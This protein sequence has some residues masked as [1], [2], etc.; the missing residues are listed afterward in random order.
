MRDQP[1]SRWVGARLAMLPALL[2]AGCTILAPI[3]RPPEDRRFPVAF[4]TTEKV[5]CFDGQ[6]QSQLCDAPLVNA[7]DDFHGGLGRALWEMDKRRSELIGQAAERTTLNATY[8]ALLWPFGAYFLAKKVHHPGW[9]ALDVSAFAV[10]TYGLLGSG[11]PDRDKLYLKTSA[12]MAC[13]MVEFDADLYLGSEVI[14]PEPS[15]PVR[16]GALSLDERLSQLRAALAAFVARRDSVLARLEL[17]ASKPG[18]HGN[19]STQQ[20]RLLAMNAATAPTSPQDPTPGILIETDRLAAEAEQQLK[21]GQALK[22]RLDSSG[23]RLRLQR[24]RMEATLAE[25]LND[26]T[27]ALDSPLKRGGEIT[28]LVQDLMTASSQVADKV[29]KQSGSG[30]SEPWQPTAARLSGLTD[31]SRQCVIGLWTQERRTLREA[32]AAVAD[33]IAQHDERVNTAKADAQAMGCSENGLSD[34]AKSLAKTLGDA[35]T[36]AA[37]ASGAGK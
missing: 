14:Q 37:A 11:I 13:A 35:A 18:K 26:R 31:E 27:P 1:A 5:P 22:R 16:P 7:I 32:Q 10:A 15:E 36:Q 20:L 21:A 12:R 19:N 2:A 24:S 34:F 4:P 3:Q 33:W 30:R 23:A 8:N 28:Q 29:R 25:A 17:T 9:S 6:G